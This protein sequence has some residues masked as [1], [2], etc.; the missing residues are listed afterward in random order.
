MLH[1]SLWIGSENIVLNHDKNFNL[2]SLRILI[3][4]LLYNL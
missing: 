1:I 2:I 4:F 3:I